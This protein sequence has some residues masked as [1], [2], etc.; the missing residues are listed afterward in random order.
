M[1][2]LGAWS[3]WFGYWPRRPHRPH[4][5]RSKMAIR[6]SFLGGEGLLR[7]LWLWIMVII[8]V[9][10]C[11]AQT[12]S[13]PDAPVPQT[14][15]P[16]VRFWSFRGPDDPPLRSVRSSLRWELAVEGMYC[17]AAVVDVKVTHGAREI[18][19]D[20]LI[21]CGV[22]GVFGFLMDRYVGRPIS[23]IPAIWGVQHHVRD[24]LQGR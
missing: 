13:L 8:L 20:S 23:L 9:P 6:R 17:A 22:L 7:P 2:N 5:P 19:S 1:N 12:A 14:D 16:V 18:Y 11:Q 15:A 3:E 24:A 21:P 4:R 10:Y